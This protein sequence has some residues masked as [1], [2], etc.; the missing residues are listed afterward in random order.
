M[1]GEIEVVSYDWVNQEDQSKDY[2][3]PKPAR[4]VVDKSVK[5]GRN[6]LA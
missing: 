2:G 5:V 4:L 6:T 1:Y 3:Q